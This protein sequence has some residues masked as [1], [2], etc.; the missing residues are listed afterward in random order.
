MSL[1]GN[2][3]AGAL[4]YMSAVAVS[5]RADPLGTAFSYQGRLKSAG[6]AAN[7]LHDLQ[8]NLFAVPA[9]GTPIAGPIC[10]DNVNVADGLFTV[11]LDFGAV[12]DGNE[13][14]L[15][16]GVR[17]DN[18][19]GNC[20]TGAYT[21]L[22]PRQAVTAAPVS[23]YSRRPWETNGA[24]L[25]YT[26]G[27]ITVGDI[28][29][30]RPQVDVRAYGATGDGITDDTDAIQAAIDSLGDTNSMRGGAVFFPPGTYQ[31]SCT[32][33][34]DRKCGVLYGVGPGSTIGTPGSILKW[35][36]PAGLPMVR[37]S[38]CW[39]TR[40]HG[41]RFVGDSGARPSAAIEM[42]ASAADSPVNTQLSL[43]WIWIGS[44]GGFDADNAAQFA[45]GIVTSGANL[46]DDQSQMDHVVVQGVTGSCIRIANTQNVLWRI[47]NA[48]LNG[49]IGAT[50]ITCGTRIM[51]LVNPF[52]ATNRATDI[53]ITNDGMLDVYNMGSEGAGRLVRAAG[54][55]Q[56]RVRGGYWQAGDNMAAD[57]NIIDISGGASL[58]RMED[59][60]FT[61]FAGPPAK[62]K[63]RGPL[64]VAIFNNVALPSTP[65]TFFDLA[66]TSPGDHRRIEFL[67]GSSVTGFVS[68]LNEWSHGETGINRNRN[69]LTGLTRL[70][71]A[72][73]QAAVFE[74]W[75]E[76][77]GARLFAV[78]STGITLGANTSFSGLLEGSEIADPGSAAPDRGKLYF[79]DDGAGKTQLVV[80]FASGPTQVLATEP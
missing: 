75:N 28:I 8:F 9:G 13:R 21:P 42:T 68:F 34:I 56:L 10:A 70:R 33:T 47:S 35:A 1:R 67:G 54:G 60:L 27:N 16:I 31:I 64:A 48:V 40:L 63:M 18:T 71:Q 3:V 30:R 46:Q 26:A 59:F 2:I 38:R 32:L 17:T 12:F 49:G 76:S 43:S 44:F 57:G 39:F 36:G 61:Q 51:M 58:V 74:V 7:G 79:R 69:D 73:G 37:I 45:D 53:E 62:C 11:P 80:Q 72:T 5:V 50:G 78:E 6:S 22:A 24:N 20:G 77:L 19:A 25:S 41:L 55:A 23:L 66:T 52:F 4:I 29:T 15:D 14:W 65:D